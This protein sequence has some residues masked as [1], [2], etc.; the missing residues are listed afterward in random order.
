MNSIGL[1]CAIPQ[2][3]K[4]IIRRFPA[5]TKLPLA[6]FPSWSFSAGNNRITLMES[7]MGQANAATATTVM[8]E[9]ARPDIILSIGFCGAVK[10]GIHV[11]DLVVAQQQYSF[12]SG[13]LTAALDPDRP[14]TERL[15][16]NLGPSSCRTG[17]FITTGIFTSKN[18]I[19]PLIPDTIPLPVLEMESAAVIHAC[20]ATGIRVAALRAV[21]DTCDED[22][23][24][25]VTEL[26]SQDFTMNKIRAATMLL[27]KPWLLPRL[28]R[29]AGNAKR[30]GDSLAKALVHTLERLE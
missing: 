4:P 22:P 5:A 3:S 15:L 27:G 16:R 6:G 24:A 12:S 25:L 26:F 10:H 7:G 19:S 28:A 14:L 8:I 20:H 9:S 18:L 30:A 21:S 11:G 1:I 17:T 2:E 29:L 13:A 23:S